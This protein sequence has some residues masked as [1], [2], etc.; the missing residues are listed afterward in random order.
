MVG[1]VDPFG[2]FLFFRGPLVVIVINSMI[3]ALIKA[4]KKVGW[5]NLV[6]L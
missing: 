5:D 3:N 4:N 1:G 6:L 2:L